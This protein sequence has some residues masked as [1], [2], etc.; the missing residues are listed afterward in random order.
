MGLSD[1]IELKWLDEK[2]AW[3]WRLLEEYGPQKKNRKGSMKYYPSNQHSLN[4]RKEDLNI[5]RWFFY[6]H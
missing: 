4:H 3:G 2:E 5:N 1:T 6:T